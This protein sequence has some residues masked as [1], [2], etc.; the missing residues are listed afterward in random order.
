[1]VGYRVVESGNASVLILERADGSNS[2]LVI[3]NDVLTVDGTPVPGGVP[4]SF[5]RAWTET[6][7]ESWRLELESVLRRL[8]ELPD[9]PAALRTHL[10]SLHVA[11]PVVP[12]GAAAVP[13]PTPAPTPAPVARHAKIGPQEA[14]HS[15]QALPPVV[16]N[17][18]GD[19]DA[20][21]APP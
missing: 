15:R 10:E 9:A 13:V 20:Q 4:E 21:A 19:W 6:V 12:A 14:Q 7:R 18:Q 17:Q 8:H 3:R 1:M 11:A 16:G 5:R 2:R